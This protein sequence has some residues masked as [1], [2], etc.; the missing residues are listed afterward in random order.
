MKLEKFAPAEDRKASGKLV[1]SVDGLSLSGSQPRERICCT[2]GFTRV[3]VIA[4][5]G[6]KPLDYLPPEYGSARRGS[7]L[8]EQNKQEF[9]P[10]K[11]NL[12]PSS[13]DPGKCTPEGAEELMGRGRGRR[14]LEAGPTHP[15]QSR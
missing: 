8:V 2:R 10:R 14:G 12:W 3:A 11:S 9:P 7:D 1:L 4:R 15:R 13:I 5:S 6:P